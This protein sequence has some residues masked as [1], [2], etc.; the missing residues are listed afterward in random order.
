VEPM[1]LLWQLQETE[2]KI[3]QKEKELQSLPSVAEYQEKKQTVKG[4]EDHL[5]RREEQHRSVK[6]ELS[7]K[8]ME[9][10]N[11]SAAL[12]ASRK[13]LYSGEVPSVKE[14]ENLEKKVQSQGREKQQLEEKVIELMESLESLEEELSGLRQEKDRETEALKQ[15]RARAKKDFQGVQQELEQLK[16]QRQQLEQKIPPE[17]VAK[18][19]EL[20]RG[21][22]RCI[23]RVKDNFCGICNVSLPSAFRAHLLTPGKEVFCENCGSLLV[24]AEADSSGE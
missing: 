11:V 6:K 18:Y 12:E 5:A 17:L 14:L 20:S 4:Q 22:K 24:L 19:R 15:V 3:M 23:S 7:R 1:Q 10:Q 13:K 2:Q 8:E 9:L 16:Q 21:G